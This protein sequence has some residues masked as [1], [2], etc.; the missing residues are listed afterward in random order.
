[1]TRLHLQFQ[2]AISHSWKESTT[3]PGKGREFWELIPRTLGLLIVGH[4]SVENIEM[5]GVP[6]KFIP[7][8]RWKLLICFSLKKINMP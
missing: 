4:F 6:K 5:Q 1:M 8:I 3:R 7:T 2:A